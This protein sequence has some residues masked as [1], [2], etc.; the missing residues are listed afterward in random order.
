MKTLLSDSRQGKEGEEAKIGRRKRRR[1]KWG[2]RTLSLFPSYFFAFFFG[3]APKIDLPYSQGTFSSIPTFFLKKVSGNLGVVV[4]GKLFFFFLG[5][6]LKSRAISSSS[7]LG[8]RRRR[9]TKG[10]G[11]IAG[12]KCRTTTIYIICER[13]SDPLAQGLKKSTQRDFPHKKGS[14][15]FL[16]LN[17]KLAFYDC[18]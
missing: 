7:S 2:S 11:W 5:P 1:R 9:G 6:C 14:Q 8:R 15:I 3:R 12:D 17:E 18:P 4:G 10:K 13:R 16:L